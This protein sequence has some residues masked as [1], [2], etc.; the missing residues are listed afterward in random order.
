MQKSLEDSAVA[1]ISKDRKV[2]IS[3]K[4]TREPRFRLDPKSA[5]ERDFVLPGNREFIPGDQIDK[6]KAGDGGSGSRRRTMPRARTI[7]NS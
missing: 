7:S 3:S 2:K 1:D 6:P 5:G 4:G